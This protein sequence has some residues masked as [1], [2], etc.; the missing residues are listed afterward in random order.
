MESISTVLDRARN[1][2]L[3]PYAPTVNSPHEPETVVEGRN[4]LMFSSNNYLGMLNDARVIAAAA[5]G[6]KKWGMAT[7]ASRLL[8]GNSEIHE[9]LETRIAGFKGRQACLTFS[10]DYMT[11]SGAIP[12]IV[13]VIKPSLLMLG[14]GFS[15]GSETVVFSDQCNHASAIAGIRV[16]GAPKEIFKHSDMADLKAKLRE[17]TKQ[18]R[19]LIVV[20]GVFGMDGDIAPLPD[21]LTLAKRYNAMVYVDDA[22]ATGILGRNG[23]GVEEYFDIEGKADVVAGT[24]EKSFGGIGG[25]VA[26][27]TELIDYLRISAKTYIFSAPIAPPVVYGLMKAL[28]L[29]RNEP[30][31]RERLMENA[32]YLREAF[33]EMGLNICGSETQIIPILIGDERKTYAAAQMLSSYGILVPTSMWPA[34]PEGKARLRISVMY[35]HTTDQL[36]YLISTI[37][38]V[39]D[40]I[41]DKRVE[42]ARRR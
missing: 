35:N 5:E 25:F 6:L 42:Y 4:I 37:R 30:W 26:G 34:V 13:D 1:M 10:T 32:R 31:R 24:L 27:S 15:S 38:K 28:E 36:D 39:R 33:L 3:Y 18:K 12:A 41:L 19:K 21:I 9:E 8:G 20:E 40:K 17:H 16:S 29:V 11:N 22:H 23:R 7:G 2:Q 14:E